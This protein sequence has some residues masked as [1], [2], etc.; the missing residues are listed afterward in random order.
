LRPTRTL[1]TRRVAPL[2]AAVALIGGAVG[3]AVVTAAPT[4]AQVAPCVATATPNPVAASDD[5]L[6]TVTGLGA[7]DSVDLAVTDPDGDTA[8][9]TQGNADGSGEFLL[10][11]LGAPD[12]TLGTWTYEFTGTPSDASCVVDVVIVA[13]P[14]TTTA[15]PSTTTTAAVAA[16]TV[17]PAFTG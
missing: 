5:F 12:V 9:G 4:G 16:V 14:P 1:L 10:P 8:S 3:V 15:A 6:I 7:N 13:D 17:T 11:E 2:A